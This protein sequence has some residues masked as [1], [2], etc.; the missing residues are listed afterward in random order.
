MSPLLERNLAQGR[1]RTSAAFID[2][3]RSVSQREDIVE[4]LHPEV[5]FD[6]DPARLVDGK[7]ATGEELGGLDAGAPNTSAGLDPL[8]GLQHQVPGPDLHRPVVEHDFD[9]ET[10][11]LP[12]GNVDHTGMPTGQEL[13]SRLNDP[14]LRP[15]RIDFGVPGEKHVLDQIMYFGSDFHSRWAAADDHEPEQLLLQSGR[16]GSGGSFETV[17]HL[18]SNR[19]RVPQLAHEESKPVDSR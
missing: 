7:A 2:Q 19:H 16:V 12:R 15:G 18:I 10:G 14:D 17:D 13:L 1:Q 4:A 6:P 8:A 11:N 3:K 9:L 5:G